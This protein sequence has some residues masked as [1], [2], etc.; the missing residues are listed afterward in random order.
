ML[1]HKLLGIVRSRILDH[2]FDGRFPL[3]RNGKTVAALVLALGYEERSSIPLMADSGTDCYAM[4]IPNQ[5]PINAAELIMRI[6]EN[7]LNGPWAMLQG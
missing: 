2:G 4:G 3:I 7:D 1:A 6:V 5:T